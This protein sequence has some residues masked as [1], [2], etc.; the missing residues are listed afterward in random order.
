[1]GTETEYYIVIPSFVLRDERLTPIAKLI[2]GEINSLSNING[3]AWVSNG[4]LAENHSVSKDTVKRAIAL[5]KDLG[6]IDTRLFYK[7]SSKEVE[8]REIFI[9]PGGKNAPRVGAEINP[10]WGQNYTDPGGKNAPDKNTVKNTSKNTVNES[11]SG[12]PDGGP[13]KEQVKEIVSFLNETAG[14]KYKPASKKTSDLIRARFA[15]GFTVEDFKTVISKKTAEWQTSE[16]MAIFIRP[17]TLFSNKFEGYLNQPVAKPVA[18]KVLSSGMTE[19]GTYANGE[20]V[21][22]SFKNAMVVGEAKE[23][24]LTDLPF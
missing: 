22:D 14:T 13:S 1:M 15:E 19:Y 20:T 24:D 16:K 23:P 6:Y 5:L 8:R 3:R 9:I 10:G 2:Y 7:E 4:K 12:K 11:V 17:E 21:I 18:G